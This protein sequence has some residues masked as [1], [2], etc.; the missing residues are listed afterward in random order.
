MFRFAIDILH[1]RFGLLCVPSICARSSESN[2]ELNKDCSPE[3][4]PTEVAIIESYITHEKEKYFQHAPANPTQ[5]HQE[6]QERWALDFYYRHLRSI[7]IQLSWNTKELQ[8]RFQNSLFLPLIPPQTIACEDKRNKAFQVLNRIYPAVLPYINSALWDEWSQVEKMQD[9]LTSDLESLF[10]LFI[11]ARYFVVMDEICSAYPKEEGKHGLSDSMLATFCSE[12]IQHGIATL[13]SKARLEDVQEAQRAIDSDYKTLFNA[14]SRK[15]Q[16]LFGLE[17]PTKFRNTHFYHRLQEVL[18]DRRTQELSKA[19]I[20]PTVPF[21]N[22]HIDT[23]LNIASP[24]QTSVSVKAMVEGSGYLKKVVYDDST[25]QIQYLSTFQIL[26]SSEKPSLVNFQGVLMVCYPESAT[27]VDQKVSPLKKRQRSVETYRKVSA[28]FMDR[29]GPIN[30]ILWN[31]L[32]DSLIEAWYKHEHHLKLARRYNSDIMDPLIVDFKNLFVCP[33]AE[34]APDVRILT[35]L[36]YLKSTK[37][38][39]GY[40]AETQMRILSKPSA[41]NLLEDVWQ[42]PSKLCCIS[43]IKSVQHSFSPPFQGSFCG[44]VS[45]I[46]ATIRTVSGPHQ[47]FNLTDVGGTRIHCTARYH[48]CNHKNLVEGNKVILFAATGLVAGEDDI[49]RLYLLKD[50][51]VLNANDESICT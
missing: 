47:D 20:S 30:I 49:W 33:F 36:R 48:C 2:M 10:E 8:H 24:Q 37:T 39:H 28:V 44:V 5:S 43:D 26:N 11:E 46:T 6:R 23:L 50:A 1:R 34:S 18:E 32:A 16:E 3:I 4:D 7:L 29:T 19:V 14:C 9:I 17:P 35:Q 31:H 27:C 38:N 45:D 12:G 40:G 15:Q 25:L 42:T 41:S 51:F 13:L 21:E 22:N